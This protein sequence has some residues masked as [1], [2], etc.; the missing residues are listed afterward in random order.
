MPKRPSSP[1]LPGK[2]KYTGILGALHMELPDGRRFVM[3][4]GLTDN[5]RRNPPQVGKLI[6]YRYRELTK[7]GMPRF[8]RCLRVRDKF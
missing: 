8:P 7:N 6:T 1:H 4:S 3:G 5:L 2:G